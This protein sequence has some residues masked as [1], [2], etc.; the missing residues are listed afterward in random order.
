MILVNG[1]ITVY[2]M[3]IWKGSNLISANMLALTVQ[4]FE[5]DRN[6]LPSGQSLRVYIRVR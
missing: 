1:R 2:R 6:G 4:D 3:R 5:F